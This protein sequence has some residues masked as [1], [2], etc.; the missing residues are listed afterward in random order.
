MPEA[1]F[2]QLGKNPGQTRTG[3]EILAVRGS[4]SSPTENG[5]RATKQTPQGFD[6]QHGG[7]LF[8]INVPAASP[9]WLR[10]HRQGQGPSAHRDQGLT[11]II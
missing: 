9:F 8:P 7:G 6:A 10:R 5:Q 4:R 11:S 3:V 2:S 1:G